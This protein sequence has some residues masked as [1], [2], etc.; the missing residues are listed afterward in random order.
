MSLGLSICGLAC[1][2]DTGVGKKEVCLDNGDSL[3]PLDVLEAELSRL[4]DR[5]LASDANPGEDWTRL[6]RRSAV[7]GDPSI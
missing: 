2:E 7:S 4:D 6:T 1:W 5:S 3:R